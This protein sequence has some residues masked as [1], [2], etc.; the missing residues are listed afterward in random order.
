MDTNKRSLAKA[1]SYR[2]LGSLFTFLI[3]FVLTGDALISSAVGFADLIVKTL[4]FY[5]HERVW[6]FIKWGHKND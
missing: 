2:L 1:V 6:N 3:A 4:L 5:L